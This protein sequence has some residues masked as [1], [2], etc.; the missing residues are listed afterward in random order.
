MVYKSK[1]K[2]RRRYLKGL[3][4]K[5][6]RKKMYG[7]Y[8]YNTLNNTL[9]NNN[10]NTFNNNDVNNNTNNSNPPSLSS[11]L[12]KIQDIILHLANIFT[13]TGIKTIE[14]KIESFI[15][16]LG[17]DTNA[18]VKD[19]LKRILTKIVELRAALETEEGKA[20]LAELEAILTKVSVEVVGPGVNKI[21]DSVI[22][23][24][25]QMAKN[26]TKAAL[27]A[28]SATPLGIVLDIPTLV[29]NIASLAKNFTT[30]AN[31]LTTIII[32]MLGKSKESRNKFTEA[33][34]KITNVIEKGNESLSNTLNTVENNLNYN[35]SA[36]QN[37]TNNDYAN[38]FANQNANQNA[39]NN[40]KNNEKN[41]ANQKG[42]LL[43]TYRQQAKMVG[44]RILQSKLEFLSSNVTKHKKTH[45]QIAK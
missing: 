9:N 31:E 2:N 38:N 33:F 32:N 44:G 7:G 34:A 42:G 29:M 12:E 4:K 1:K 10:A 43:N 27:A 35:N 13:A 17:I 36:N 19:E 11:N 6:S 28:F 25:G 26:S 22:E 21:A 14:S 8:P 16:T 24:S 30:L 37:L 18:D 3:P 20:A 5:Q 41:F 15:E 40:E 45:K 39:N 23:H